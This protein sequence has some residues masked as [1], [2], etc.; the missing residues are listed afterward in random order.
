[1]NP[2]PIISNDIQEIFKN[3]KD[4]LK[5]IQGSTWLISGGGGFIGAYILDLLDCCNENLFDEPCH[6]ICMD[7][8]ITGTSR[9]IKH[10]ADKKHVKILNMNVA[11]PFCLDDQIDYVV[12]TAGIASPTY[13]KKHPIETIEANVIGLKNLLDLSRSN[14]VKSILHFS[15]SEIYGDPS[16]DN[17]PTNESYNG[18]VSCTGPRACYDESKRL[19]ETL[20]VN[21]YQQYGLPIKAVRPFNIYGPGL[22]LD[23]RRVIPDFFQDALLEGCI[24][25]YSDGS[26]TRSFCYINDAIIGFIHVLLSDCNGE[27]FNI[28][29][30][31]KE[32]R[33]K[34]LATV[35]S[36]IVGGVAVKYCLNEDGGYLVHNP[37]RRMPDLTK[38][39]KLLGYDPCISLRK[40]LMRLY[41]W[42]LNEYELR[43][44]IKK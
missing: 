41:N 27:A 37:I 7:N 28:G 24:R 9:R 22:K 17:I 35:I 42:Y 14:P 20:C 18:N 8:F 6:I 11:K 15:S 23:D 30:D 21:Y 19:S 16:P 40:G 2:D 4:K 3:V 39:R 38:A 13:Y 10:L 31:E 26:P 33:I 12:H 34:E 36:D 25:I 5:E 44:E 1:M 29:N 43:K 32:I